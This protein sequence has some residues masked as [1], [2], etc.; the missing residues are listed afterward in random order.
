MTNAAAQLHRIGGIVFT[1]GVL[2]QMFLAGL[3][4]FGAAS[5]VPHVI[6]GNVL[7]LVA[8]ILLVAALV[9]RRAPATTAVL[10]VFTFVQML[11]VWVSEVAP[12]IA[13]LHPVNTL[14]LLSL[15]HS[16][17]RGVG[18][19]AAVPGRAASVG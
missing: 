18:L 9:A 17:A 10:L 14:V 19:S 5:F 12:V 11:L 13:A 7:L 2:V 4:L 15:G 3:G 16:V 6:L 8:L 1:A